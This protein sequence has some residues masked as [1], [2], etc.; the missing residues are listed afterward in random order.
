MTQ[1]GN[2]SQE[3]QPTRMV[4]RH[5]PEL[6]TYLIEMQQQ[7]SFKDRTYEHFPAMDGSPLSAVVFDTG[8]EIRGTDNDT[9]EFLVSYMCKD[10]A[11]EWLNLKRIPESSLNRLIEFLNQDYYAAIVKKSNIET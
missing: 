10:L 7:R 3:L 6:I 4:H 11:P 2:S 9:W 8:Y 5:A 1:N